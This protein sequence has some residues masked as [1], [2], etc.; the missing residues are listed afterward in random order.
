MQLEPLPFIVSP[1]EKPNDGFIETKFAFC[2]KNFNHNCTN[3]YNSI[4]DKIGEFKCPYGFSTVAT[5]VNGKKK[6]I[7]SIELEGANDRKALKKNKKKTDNKKRFTK[8][9][10]NT[11]L[12]WYKNTESAILAKQNIINDLDKQSNK[13]TQ[14]EEV[15]DDTLHELRKLNNALKKQAFYLRTEIEKESVNT[16]EF[17]IRTKNILST[18]QLISARLNAY[19]FTLNPGSIELNPKVKVN[20]YKK[21][22][23]A[24]H[25]LEL[26]LKDKNQKI[27]FYGNCHCLNEFYELIDVL[28][29]ILF[30][31]AMKYSQENSSI[32]CRFNMKGHKIDSIEVINKAFLPDINEIPKLFNKKYR[33]KATTDVSGTGIGLFIAQMICDYNGIDISIDTRQETIINNKP[34]GEFKVRLRIASANS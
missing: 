28:P 2:D 24:S 18:S 27:N 1:S 32:D 4:I 33:G 34:Y 13:V 31:N 6:I 30:E 14:K 22:E 8:N 3:H 5:L 21:F 10:L 19:D 26:F 25:T 15:L 17:L 7:T 23:K 9:E 16:N 11:L 12:E 20:I 29:F